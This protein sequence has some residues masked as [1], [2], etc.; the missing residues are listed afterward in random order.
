MSNFTMV[1]IS[2]YCISRSKQLM[3]GQFYLTVFLVYFYFYSR[4]FNYKQK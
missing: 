2:G 1:L 4:I 3:L